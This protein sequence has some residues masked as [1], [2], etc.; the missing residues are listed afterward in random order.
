MMAGMRARWGLTASRVGALLATAGLFVVLLGTARAEELSD[1]PCAASGT[2][3]KTVQ[4]GVVSANACW[5]QTTADGGTT[6]QARWSEQGSDGVDLNGFI[7]TGPSQG[8]LE[9][10]DKTRRLRSVNISNDKGDALKTAQFNSKNWPQEGAV[11]RM[12]EPVELDFDIPNVGP[13][14]IEDFRFGSDNSFFKTLA[15]FSPVGTVETPVQ[16]DEEG[17]GSM[18]LAI[19]VSGYYTLKGKPQSVTIKLPTE[20]GKGTE[21]DGFEVK[22]EE[23]DA[24]KVVKLEEFEAEYSKSEKKLAGDATIVFPFMGS[25]KGENEKGISGGFALEDGKLT[26]LGLGVTGL[27]IPIGAP[28]GGFI[29]AI[30]GGLDVKEPDTLLVSAGLS[31]TL[32]KEV[33]LPWGNVAPVDLDAAVKVG[34]KDGG[35]FFRFDGGMKIFRIPVGNAYLIIQSNA[36]VALGVSLGM[37]IPSFTNNNRDPFYIGAY[38]TGWIGKGMWQFTG[39]ADIKALNIDLIKGDAMVNNRAIGACWTILFRGGVVYP[40]GGSLIAFPINTC[41]L[42]AYEEKNPFGAAPGAERPMPITLGKRQKL[43]RIKA[44]GGIPRFD[45]RAADGRLIKGPVGEEFKRT[46]NWAIMLDTEKNTAFVMLRHPAGRWSLIPRDGSPEI[47]AVHANTVLPPPRVRA[48]V[49]GKGL[50]RTLVWNSTGH[51]NTELVFTEKTPGGSEQPVLKTRKAKG[52][53]RFKAVNGFGYG[54]RRLKVL[55]LHGHGPMLNRVVDR[56]V[57]RRPGRL[58]APRWVR[59]GRDV[60]DVAV[61]W[62]GVRGASGYLVQLAIR[63]GAKLRTSFVKVTG[64]K[65]RQW[66]VRKHPGGTRAVARVYALNIDGEP[67]RL[68]Q[69]SFRTGPP[70][71]GLRAAARLT[72]RSARREGGKVG[73][74]AICPES[75]HCRTVIALS[76]GGRTIR[77]AR[78]Q[79]VP[80]TFRR[81]VIAP[82]SP[83]LRRRIARGAARN[84]KVRVTMAR[85]D[86]RATATARP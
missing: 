38:V 41:G 14:T 19:M 75:G 23:I 1:K 48:R 22:L 70:N 58:R 74:R 16:L 73:L 61:R 69:V 24:F 20:L 35:F 47:T 67:G 55:V 80:D 31:A 27:D 59:A 78:F 50:W 76:V 13:F 29:T 15:G 7:L 10:N 53:F 82:A 45:L 60:H 86:Q 8:A 17:K 34:M 25:P 51:P 44:E 83:S 52:K 11:T 81:V 77:T 40:Y 54:V 71:V 72:A 3:R 5:R 79:Q 63:N 85:T 18:D 42:G 39:G 36:G 2:V 66:T 32:G 65:A 46:R 6:W 56:F 26:H 4:V 49:V 33:K 37:G 43:L 68:R 21:L 57:V 30:N 28:P 64:P 9:I 84:L 12:G 62:A